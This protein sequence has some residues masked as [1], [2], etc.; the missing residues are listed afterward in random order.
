[1]TGN[2]AVAQVFDQFDRL[3]QVRF[4][5]FRIGDRLDIGADIDA[6]DVGA[7]S[8]RRMA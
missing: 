3:G 4:G 7:S 8:A 1:M 2:H 5:C 6:D